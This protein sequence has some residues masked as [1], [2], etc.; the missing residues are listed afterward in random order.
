MRELLHILYYKL[1][2]SLK[3]TLELNFRGLVKNSG[4]VILYGIFAFGAYYF[5]KT[6]IHYLLEEARI[7]LFLLHRFL[8]M[9]LFVFF[10][11]VNLGNIIVS[12][13]TLYRSKE[14]L[15]FFTKPVSFTNLFFI[16]FLDNF[17]YSSTTLLLIGVSVIIGYGSY[18]A[19]PF[20]FYIIL[21]FFVFLP[22]MLIAA[23]LGVLI[24]FSVVKLASIFGGIPTIISLVAGYLASIIL[25]FRLTNPSKLV[26]D[27][28]Q[29]Y[30][31]IDRYLGQFD[32]AFFK[33]LPNHWA[34]EFLY[35]TVRGELTA[36]AFYIMVFLSV[37]VI[38]LG[39][40]L[41]IAKNFY[42][43]SWLISLNIFSSIGQIKNTNL[44]RKN[45]FFNPQTDVL[46]KKEIIQFI[47]E[48]S[49]WIHFLV[50]IFLILIFSVSLMNY[51]FQGNQPF[52]QAIFYIVVYM[53]TAFL[54]ASLSLRFVYPIIGMEA[55]NFWKI[56]SAPI[57]L[58]KF[59]NAKYF[60]TLLPIFLIC[61]LLSLF[62][63]WQLRNDTSL[64]VLSNFSLICV[65]IA[66]LTVNISAGTFFSSFNEKNPIRIAS[67]QG[68]SLTFLISLLFLFLI[69][70]IMFYSVLQ[71]FEYSK[72]KILYSLEHG[73]RSLIVVFIISFATGVVFYLLGIKSLK[74][75]YY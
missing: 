16:K 58:V 6:T 59:F 74:R 73:M 69:A 31:D 15:F 65:A 5:T 71:Y 64:F 47:R 43:K 52:L 18:F 54:M 51:N 1:I 3:F 32:P 13:S 56:K 45:N 75:D 37:S 11:T 72:L 9:V 19:L 28:M 70:A 66:I 62:T 36:G 50:M 10:L 30:P 49:Q 63:N 35:W 24:L 14:V 2:S 60:F 4:S 12:Y 7:G 46:L 25:Y 40:L 27:I 42:R 44:F 38:L 23:I 8:S 68:A 53:F 20:S 67:T 26:N 34:A 57:S 41:Y 29:L 48:P 17:F 39:L 21:F 33:Y 61:G 55:K 22:F